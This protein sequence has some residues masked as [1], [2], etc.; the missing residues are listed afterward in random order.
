MRIFIK[1][2]QHHLYNV[3]HT[4]SVS[5][6]LHS[7]TVCRIHLYTPAANQITGPAAS[8]RDPVRQTN[9]EK[10]TLR[11]YDSQLH[12]SMTNLKDFN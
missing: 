3:H 11:I 8:V 6:T 1:V 4:T 9:F 12:T 2:L 10:K 7:L 5:Q